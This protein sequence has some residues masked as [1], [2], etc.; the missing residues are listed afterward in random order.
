MLA[1]GDDGLEAVSRTRLAAGQ[2][3]ER[4]DLHRMLLRRVN[5][6]ICPL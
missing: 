4:Q 3:R 1:R 5:E 6:H 2:V